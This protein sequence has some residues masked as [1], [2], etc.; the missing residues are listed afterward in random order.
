MGEFDVLTCCGRTA[1]LH[2]TR[3]RVDLEKQLDNHKFEFD[4]LFDD[5]EGNEAVYQR[6]AQ[7]LIGAVFKGGR[8]TCFAYGQTGSGKT[9]T[10]E[11]SQPSGSAS[12]GVYAM[13]SRDCFRMI[14]QCSSQGLKL[15]LGLSMFEVYREGVF[16]LLSRAAGE[17]E[18]TKLQ[19][20]ED[21]QGEVQLMGLTEFIVDDADQVLTLLSAA[22]LERRTGSNSVNERS[23][24]SHAV[25]QFLLRT[26]DESLYGKVCSIF[27]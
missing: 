2:Q 16:D 20:L 25:V 21:G 17:S 23:S 26:V 22:R 12:D 1:V 19:V 4:E 11:G 10:M 13:T 5:F 7:P 8:A 18:S 14:R 3:K 27:L 9:Y 24:R 15:Q 6:V